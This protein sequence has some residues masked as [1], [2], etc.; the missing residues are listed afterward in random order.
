MV[1]T[2]RDKDLI[3]LKKGGG[4]GRE[5]KVLIKFGCI[6]NHCMVIV[7]G[8]LGQLLSRIHFVR[9]ASHHGKVHAESQ[10]AGVFYPERR[11][12]WRLSQKRFKNVFSLTP[13]D[14][15]DC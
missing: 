15:E 13:E 2:Q 4:G 5:R 7:T 1:D 8:C 9:A 10:E 6:P 12:C 14:R 11:S 3:A